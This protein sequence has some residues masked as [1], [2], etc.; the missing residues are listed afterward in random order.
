[1][2]FIIIKLG[3]FFHSQI[4]HGHSIPA[5]FASHYAILFSRFVT[6]VRSSYV[7]EL[8]FGLCPNGFN[9]GSIEGIS[10]LPSTKVEES[11]PTTTPCPL[12]TS[13]SIP[14]VLN[15]LSTVVREPPIRWW[16][17]HV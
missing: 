7:I 16:Y 11:H 13:S 4:I 9:G 10:M 6:C 1:M 3:F 12:S 17:I 15:T 5:P 14:E 2:Y 8:G